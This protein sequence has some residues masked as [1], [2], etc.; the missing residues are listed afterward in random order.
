[1]PV[2]DVYPIDDDD[3]LVSLRCVATG[4]ECEFCM[5]ST[6]DGLTYFAYNLTIKRY[7]VL[8]FLKHDGQ[9]YCKTNR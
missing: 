4:K 3:N 2:S 9:I 8:S 1:M 6:F 7:E 5:E